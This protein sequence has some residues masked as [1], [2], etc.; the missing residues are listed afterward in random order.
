MTS[1]STTSTISLWYGS[2]VVEAPVFVLLLVVLVPVVLSFEKLLGKDKLLVV[3]T[4]MVDVV[5]KVVD[6][7]V[8]RVSTVLLE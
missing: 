6:V 3:V 1:T 4:F 2:V 5:E 8:F 7:Y